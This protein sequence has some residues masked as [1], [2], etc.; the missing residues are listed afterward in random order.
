MLL[1]MERDERFGQ[2]VALR[3]GR[4][5]GPKQLHLVKV[6]D[7]GLTVICFIARNTIRS[8][9]SDLLLNL[10][11]NLQYLPNIVVQMA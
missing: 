6:A 7:H 10:L 1:D 2:P 11:H 9:K 3:L 4:Y 8:G 5:R